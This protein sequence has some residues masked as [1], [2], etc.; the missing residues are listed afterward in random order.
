MRE[1]K[2]EREGNRRRMGSWPWD[3]MS[4]DEIGCGARGE[5]LGRGG[6]DLVDG[7]ALIV[8]L[9]IDG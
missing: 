1:E 4:E 3:E 9:L 5:D 6:A 7:V 2:E 8:H